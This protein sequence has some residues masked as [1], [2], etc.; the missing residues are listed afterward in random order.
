MNKPVFIIAEAGVNH[1]GS[2]DMALELVD[3]AAAAA[4]DAIKFQTF[5][6]NKL[7]TRNAPKA[8]YQKRSTDANESQLDML[9]SLQLSK[10]DH[11]AIIDRCADREIQFLSTPFDHDSLSL[12]TET[13]GL[14]QIKLGSGELTNAPLLWDV[15]RAGVEVILSTGMGTLSEVEQALGVLALAMT[16]PDLQP[17]RRAFA[18]ALTDPIAWTLL[19]DRVTLQHCTTEYPAAAE[20][21][22]LRVMDTLTQAFG[23]KVGYSDHTDGN[24]IS[25][26]AVARGACIIEKHFT[27]S[28]DLPGPDHAA[29]LDP[30]KLANL[31][32]EIRTVERAIGTGIKQPSAAERANR[33]VA[34]KSL[35]AARDLPEGHVLK[36]ADVEVKRPGDGRTPMEYW[37]VVGSVLNRSLAEGEAID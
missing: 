25:L 21:T 16:N 19:Q 17:S 35:I 8:D 2:L 34:R 5:N 20:D 29:S 26:A 28:R 10:A 7:V 33:P 37:E 12:L 18:E 14:S 36:L 1:N 6:A 32:A 4:A 27:L 24:A 15:G 9:L 23:L 30:S 11:R 3:C 13:L 31:V 22:N